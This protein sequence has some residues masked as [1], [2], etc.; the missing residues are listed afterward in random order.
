MWVYVCVYTWWYVCV[1][2][3]VYD[4][5]E[6]C[7]CRREERKVVGLNWT[8]EERSSIGLLSPSQDGSFYLLRIVGEQQGKRE[9]SFERSVAL[10]H[11]GTTRAEALIAVLSASG[12]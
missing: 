9:S 3:Y 6:C 8:K 11:L 2:V 5:N 10:P 4:S 1:C 7:V 12:R